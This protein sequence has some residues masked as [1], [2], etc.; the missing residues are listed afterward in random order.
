MSDIGSNNPPPVEAHGMNIND[1]YDEA[2]GWLDGAQI[3]TQDQADGL[4][5]LLDHI[6]IARKAADEQRATEKRP[7]DDA[8]KAVQQAWKPLLDKCDLAASVARQALTPWLRKLEDEQRAARI[9]ADQEAEAARLKALEAQRAAAPDDLVAQEAARILDDA[10]SQAVKDAK[11]AGKAK[12][13]ATGGTRAVGLRTSW[14][15]EITDATAFGRWAWQHRREDY[16]AFL[17]QLADRE[18]RNGPAAIPGIIVHEERK[19]A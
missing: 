11:R 5:K 9:K 16:M 10:A 18:G 19:V 12:A 2:K 6:R 7:H 14:R 4:G 8:A 15:A 3:E 1:L 13:H 17:T